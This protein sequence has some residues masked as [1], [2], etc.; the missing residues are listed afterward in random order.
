V[1]FAPTGLAVSVSAVLAATAEPVPV[2]CCGVA[3]DA[4]EVAQLNAVADVV[5]TSVEVDGV[6][7]SNCHVME[8]GT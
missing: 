1:L 8:A 6:T 4:L 3:P 5:Q 7:V 2:H